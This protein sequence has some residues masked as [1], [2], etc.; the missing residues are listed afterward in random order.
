LKKEED[1]LALCLLAFPV[2]VKVK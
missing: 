1:G 2:R